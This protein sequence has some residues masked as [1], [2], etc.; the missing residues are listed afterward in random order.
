ML[1]AMAHRHGLIAG[2]TGTGKTT[3]LIELIRQITSKGQRVL[4]VAPS[5]IA[6]DTLFEKLVAEGEKAI[7]LHSRS[8]YL[9]ATPWPVPSRQWACLCER[10]G[11]IFRYT[12][13]P[14]PTFHDATPALCRVLDADEY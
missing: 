6:V 3:T 10:F 11:S 2:A 8:K 14:F 13:V 9:Y 5:N 4:A 12:L 1:P 7:P